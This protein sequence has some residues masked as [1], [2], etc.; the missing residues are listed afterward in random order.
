MARFTQ[1]SVGEVQDRAVGHDL[2]VGSM[3]EGERV[4]RT[5][6]VAGF[7]TNVPPALTSRFRR[8]AVSWP[9]LSSV[10]ALQRSHSSCVMVA[11]VR[12]PFG[13]LRID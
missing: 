12:P 11:W 13:G 3:Q 7:L 4:P 9:L 1:C 10:Y 6:L 8:L 2:E 5:A